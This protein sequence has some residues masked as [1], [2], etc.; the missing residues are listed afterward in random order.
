MADGD[1]ASSSHFSPGRSPSSIG[2]GLVTVDD[3]QP[4]GQA[5]RTRTCVLDFPLKLTSDKLQQALNDGSLEIVYRTIG[6]RTKSLIGQ[7]VVKKP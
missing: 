4:P 3:H 1:K 7:Y 6:Y 2:S 5:Q